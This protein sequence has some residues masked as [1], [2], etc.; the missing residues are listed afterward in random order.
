MRTHLLSLALSSAAVA[1]FFV[2]AMTGWIW[3]YASY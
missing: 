1:L 2:N 3:P